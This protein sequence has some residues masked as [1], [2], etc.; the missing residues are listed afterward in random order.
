MNGVFVVAIEL[1]YKPV[2]GVASSPV[3]ELVLVDLCSTGSEDV[4]VAEVRFVDGV[5]RVNGR[6]VVALVNWLWLELL[7]VDG[8]HVAVVGMLA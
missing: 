1:L 7:G 3:T 5:G 4:F 8:T 2:D 6:V